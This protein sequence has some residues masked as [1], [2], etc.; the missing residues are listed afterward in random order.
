SMMDRLIVLL[1]LFGSAEPEL[2]PFVRR[3]QSHCPI[4]TFSMQSGPMGVAPVP[5]LASRYRKGRPADGR[6]R[7]R[8]RG[9][10]SWHRSIGQTETNTKFNT[11]SPV[12]SPCR[13][14]FRSI[15][16]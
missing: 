9:T 6:A 3:V 16:S 7:L 13:S 15:D 5:R 2:G 4:A 11:M 10:V 12:L 1:W 8:R 14:R